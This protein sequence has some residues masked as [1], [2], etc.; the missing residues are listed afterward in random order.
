MTS[1][2]RNPALL[3]T[4]LRL[5]AQ[6]TFVLQNFDADVLW[7]H[8]HHWQQPET[9]FLLC[10]LLKSCLSYKFST[11]V[12]VLFS[13]L[14]LLSRLPSGI[15][16]EIVTKTDQFCTAQRHVQNLLTKAIALFCDCWTVL[17]RNRDKGTVHCYIR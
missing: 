9:V 8:R 14:P 16:N 12:A 7:T 17:T 13:L 6:G 10:K 2:L 11:S 1:N 3:F 15:K 5:L 4:E